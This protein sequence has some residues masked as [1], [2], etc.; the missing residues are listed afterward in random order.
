MAKA[1]AR[2]RTRTRS[3]KR[4]LKPKHKV[5]SEEDREV[6]LARIEE[7]RFQAEEERRKMG[8]R[9]ND[10]FVERLLT[11]VQAGNS[12]NAVAYLSDITPATLHTWLREGELDRNDTFKSRFFSRYQKARALAEHRNLL[13]IQQGRSNWQASAWFLE[14]RAPKDY[15]RKLAVG[16]D[17]DAPP[18]SHEH[19]FDEDELDEQGAMAAMRLIVNR[20]DKKKRKTGMVGKGSGDGSSKSKS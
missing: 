4:R 18:I 16:G 8:L 10:E 9:G 5:V 14:R 1:Q 6:E 2:T 3:R 11:F 15:G 20:Q 13:V 17:S 12:D 7:E 19:E